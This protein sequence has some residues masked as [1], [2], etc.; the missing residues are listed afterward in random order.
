M[1]LTL[2]SFAGIAS[3]G[4]QTVPENPESA[5]TALKDDV[6]LGS[7]EESEL[8]NGIGMTLK[9]IASGQFVMGSSDDD[10]NHRANEGPQNTVKISNEFY[11]G[12]TEVT[13]G[14]WQSIMGTRPWLFQWYVKEG[15]TY[16]AMY[17]SWD[18]AVSFCR[19]LSDQEK[20]NYRLPTEAEWEYACRGG[21]GSKFCFGDDIRLL[22]EYAWFHEN[23]GD[24]ISTKYPHPVGQKKA[25]DF[26][27][28][29]MHGNMWEL[30][31]DVY[32][33]TVYQER[34]GNVVDPVLHAVGHKSTYDRVVR[35]GSWWYRGRDSRS[36]LRGRLPQNLPFNSSGFR[37]VM[38]ISNSAGSDAGSNATSGDVPANPLPALG[39]LPPQSQLNPLC[40]T[41]PRFVAANSRSVAANRSEPRV[42]DSTPV[43]QQ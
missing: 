40:R 9:R 21:S 7:V 24:H 11:I 39:S 28:F 42:T 13:Q 33:D 16:P 19:K 1:L 38:D 43:E 8:T 14:Q 17:I 26:G 3:G 29:D 36:A 5:P 4:E 27:L 34:N 10:T 30:C 12:T 32:S 37:V 15:S 23:S 6:L 25:N 20:S 22:D 31:Q 41:H 35:G 18:D 2:F